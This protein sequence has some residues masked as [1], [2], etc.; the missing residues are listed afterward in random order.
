V[1]TD[2][3]A[4]DPQRIVTRQDFGRQLT[5]A[6]E[7][8]GLT[9]RQIAALAGIPT[10]TLGGYLAGRH[11]PDRYPPDLLPRILEAC[12]I[13]KAGSSTDIVAQW[14]QA[15]WRIRRSADHREMIAGRD[16]PRGLDAEAEPREPPGPL[17][18]AEGVSLIPVSTVP[19]LG[20]LDAEPAIRG[21]RELL[22][23][24]R[25][26]GGPPV[27]VLHGLGGCG[28]SAVALMA[29][30]EAVAAGTRCWWLAAH[31]AATL[32]AGMTAVALE[33]HASP[34]ELRL[35]SLPDMV[36]R[37]LDSLRE[38]W[39]LV[40]DEADD[41]P[42]ILALP[43]GR[44]TDGTGW[45]RSPGSRLG[46]VIVTTRDTSGKTW[47]EPHPGWLRLCRVPGLSA[48]QSADVLLE[49]AG[50][51]AGERQ[52]AVALAHRLGGLPL[53]LVLAGRYLSE[54]ATLPASWATPD[55][56]AGFASYLTALERGAGG[57][58]LPGGSAY[59]TLSL[60][61][62]LSLDLVADRGL[63]NARPLL[64]L[65]S[66]LGP[67]PIPYELLLRS[68]ILSAS[69]LFSAMS[70]GQ[71]WATLRGLGDVGLIELGTTGGE[72]RS[73][74]LHPVV[75]DISR[76]GPAVRRD[77]PAYLALTTALLAPVVELSDPKQP[78]D[79]PRWRLLADHCSAPLDLV[80]EPGL[81][82]P[83]G[84][85]ELAARA[86][87]FLRT[88]GYLAQA[89]ATYAIVQDIARQKL[90]ARDPRTI[91]L[92][93]DVARLRYDQ[94]RL[95]EA[96]QLFRQVADLRT[97]TLGAHHP[98][99]LTSQHQLARILRDRGR[100]TEAE[101][102]LSQTLQARMGVLGETHPDTLTSSNGMADLLRVRG[103]LTEAREAYQQVLD[104]RGK[105]LGER[106][107]A[108]LTTRHYLAQVRHRLDEPGSEG[109]LRALI[110]AND[111]VRGASH[112]R[113]LAVVQ[114]LVEVLHDQGRLAEAAELVLQL[115]ADRS[116]VLGSAHPMTLVSRHRL[117]LIL[118]DRGALTEARE[119][120]AAVL[121]DRERVLGPDHLS[122]ILSRE[123]V[124]AVRQRTV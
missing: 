77:L 56:P 81:D 60:T 11:L 53:A 36:W 97:A 76:R 3:P 121:A 45:L 79:W 90:S 28:K 18:I 94:G 52:A 84:A 29:A 27:H 1:T 37:L 107:P 58:P 21:R 118:L 74:V 20:R 91:E 75:R 51:G 113:T 13:S 10:S 42:G 57:E 33:L 26:A 103:Q 120:L 72:V 115:V 22:D 83:P 40:L 87:G 25:A 41:P 108:T 34:E 8:S 86:A 16:S 65:L 43:G 38:P 101:T 73:L 85:I 102:L 47:G 104:L 15:Y 14:Q 19:P 61:W 55:L 119:L 92:Q 80:S 54:V 70:P 23:S 48:E 63:G 49:V 32:A 67:A 69:P 96:E 24:L 78:G 110:T 9:V 122:T 114:S 4:P 5:L 111:E 46:A 88:A 2:L 44:V 7:R 31:D 50:P 62:E 82:V 109:E 106:H 17:R 30:R 39:L 123:T 95:R 116:R 124:E 105:V 66:C 98:D 117:G 68:D 71:L 6:K 112:P 89:D 100:L 35:G 12:G 64:R 59:V 99:T 93:H